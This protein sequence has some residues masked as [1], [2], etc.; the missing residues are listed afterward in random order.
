MKP[1]RNRDIAAELREIADLMEMEDTPWKPRAYRRAASRIDGMEESLSD[2]YHE[3]GKK[4]LDDIPTIGDAL[5]THISEFIEKG[6]VKKWEDIKRRT[7]KG[8]HQL[9]E[10]EGL[11]PSK[12]RELA[13]K[14]DIHT[15]EDL[16][17]AAK[18]GKIGTLKGFGRKT[19][20]N[21]LSSIELYER[22]LERMLISKAMSLAWGIIEYL[23]EHASMRKIDYAGSLRRMKET[24]GDID[25]LAVTDDPQAL[26]ET[27]TRMP[28]VSRILL[29]GKTK[30]SVILEDGVHVDLRVIEN[31]SYGAAMQYFTGSKDH[32]IALRR[33]AVEKGY[34]LSEY[35]L[36][37][38]KDERKIAGADERDIYQKLGLAWIP[39]EMREDRGELDLARR[40]RIPRLIEEKDVRGDL[41]MHTTYSDGIETIRD[42]ARSAKALGHEYIAITDHSISERIAGGMDKE[43]LRKELREIDDIGDSE[44]IRILKGAEVDIKS[45]GTLD[46][47]EETLNLLDIVLVSIHTGFKKS[48]EENTR[49]LLHAIRNPGVNILAHPTGRILNKRNPYDAD[50]EAVF[51]ECA[52]NTVALEINCDPSRLDLDSSMILSAKRH[53]AV[54]SIGTD[55]HHRDSLRNIRYGVA[56][57]R[58]GWLEKK[59]VINTLP[60]EKLIRF[61]KS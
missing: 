3:K 39:P 5:A 2:I 16:K 45:D 58:R 9:M 37:R 31:E 29:K 34:K 46:Y 10:V 17:T 23:R 30:T 21:I 33:I 59:D 26:M 49:R 36:F 54:F 7:Q 40:G 19:E 8:V 15:I 11:G 27:F 51:R 20:E 35:G 50:Y 55:A 28:D 43:K 60:Y 6:S 13:D 48:R 41:Q 25:I 53:G 42:M 57:A 18:Q 44:G 61:L 22:S 32:N 14:L 47:D 1:I 24:I 56:Q 4:G 52:K 12:V 38:K